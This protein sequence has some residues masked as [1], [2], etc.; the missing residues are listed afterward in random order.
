MLVWRYLD[1]ADAPIGTS[2]PFDDQED[3]EAWLTESWRDLLAEGVEAVELTEDDGQPV[4]RMS[5]R[6]E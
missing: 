3:A 6:P 5:L 4:Y 1:S 2:D